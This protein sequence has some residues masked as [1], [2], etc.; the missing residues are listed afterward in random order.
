MAKEK[1]EKEEKPKKSFE[2]KI[3][4]WDDGEMDVE[5]YE[6]RQNPS[7]R[8]APGKWRL[9]A[10]DF[11]RRIEEVLGDPKLLLDTTY[12]AMGG[13]CL[14]E[15][16]VKKVVGDTLKANKKQTPSVEVVETT[17]A[18]APKKDD[19]DFGDFD[20]KKGNKK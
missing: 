13:L 11:V 20:D 17:P 5:M 1:A 7:G 19:M 16:E 4:V 3:V 6:Y 12:D 8:G 18:E 14:D 9:K 15:Q 2:A 10:N